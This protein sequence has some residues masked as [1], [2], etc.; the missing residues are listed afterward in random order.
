[1]AL[2][3]GERRNEEMKKVLSAIIFE[4]KDP[5]I[6]AMTTVTGVELTPDL[7]YAKARISVYEQDDDARKGTI[8]ALM[9][10]ERHIA[11]EVGQRIRIR[12]VPQFKF[13]LDDSIAY[14][15]HIADILSKL[16]TDGEAAKE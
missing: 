10:A 4:M 9:H 3:R 16:K 11:Y 12:I 6:S 1:M 15:A 13:L 8:D 14:S 7:K 5:R 2:V